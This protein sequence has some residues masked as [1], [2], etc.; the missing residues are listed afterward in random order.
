MPGV[1]NTAQEPVSPP[2]PHAAQSGPADVPRQT[3]Q[4]PIPP[5]KYADLLQQGP[6]KDQLR[7]ELSLYGFHVVK[8]AIP[9]SRAAEY[10]SRAHQWLENHGLGYD[11]NDEATWT[12]AHLP[13]HIKG[14]MFSSRVYHERWLWDVR[15]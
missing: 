3:P 12:N 7:Q 8:G 4:I 9:E 14:G 5:H 13:P 10:R 15:T 11:R 6:F 1:T 2:T